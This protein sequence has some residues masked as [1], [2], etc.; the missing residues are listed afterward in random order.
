MHSIV[1]CNIFIHSVLC[2]CLCTKL[3]PLQA[4]YSTTSKS[5]SHNKHPLQ[6]KN[7]RFEC[8][9]NSPLTSAFLLLVGNDFT[10]VLAG[11]MCFPFLIIQDCIF[12][13][14]CVARISPQLG[15]DRFLVYFK[16]GVKRRPQTKC[17]CIFHFW[18]IQ[19]IQ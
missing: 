8:G 18:M 14:P 3:I 12:F 9:G 10:D 17:S 11:D 19:F 6:N 2:L 4:L 13:S 1:K 5:G 16:F 15:R 7:L